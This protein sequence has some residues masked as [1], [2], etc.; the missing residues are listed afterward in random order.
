MPK[1]LTRM[2]LEELERRLK[3]LE[4][5]Y[6]KYFAGA[7]QFEPHKLKKE[8]EGMMRQYNHAFSP[9]YAL[10]FRLNSL[11]ARFNTHLR[12]WERL[13]AAKEGATGTF[14]KRPKEAEGAE[15]AE[16]MPAE[17]AKEQAPKED[18]LLK[19]FKD[20]TIARQ[21]AEIPGQI[22]LEGFKKTIEKRKATLIEQLQCK[23]VRFRVDIKEGKVKLKA[24]PVW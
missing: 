17:K 9:S 23:D 4:F 5:E 1:I 24:K 16:D 2:N 19:L 12:H 3:E 7:K 10:G 20:F 18:E 21:L 15:G 11:R 8:V 6:E 22:T 13:R 14:I